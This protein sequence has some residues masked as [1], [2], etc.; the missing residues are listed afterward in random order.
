MKELTDSTVFNHSDKLQMH[1]LW[2]TYTIGYKGKIIHNQQYTEKIGPLIA[3]DTMSPHAV[4][5]VLCRA[6]QSVLLS[7]IML[8]MKCDTLTLPTDSSFVRTAS[9]LIAGFAAMMRSDIHRSLYA[10]YLKDQAYLEEGYDL[11]HTRNRDY[12]MDSLEGAKFRAY[13]QRAEEYIKRLVADSKYRQVKKVT[14]TDLP[15]CSI[16]S[17]LSALSK[18]KNV[19]D[20]ERHA[21]QAKSSISINHLSYLDEYISG[22]HSSNRSI[23]SPDIGH[24]THSASRPRSKKLSK[25]ASHEVLGKSSLG[26]TISSNRVQ[27]LPSRDQ[28]RDPKHC[29]SDSAPVPVASASGTGLHIGK[30]LPSVNIGKSVDQRTK[31]ALL[32]DKS[33]KKRGY[34]F[35]N[36]M[37]SAVD[38]VQLWLPSKLRVAFGQLSV[39]GH[40]RHRASSDLWDSNEE[41]GTEVDSNEEYGS[42]GDSNEE[43]SSEEDSNEEHGSEG[44][45]NEEYSSEGDSGDLS[46]SE[47]FNQN[48]QTSVFSGDSEFTRTPADIE[49]SHHSDGSN[50]AELMSSNGTTSSVPTPAHSLGG[51]FRD[52]AAV[53]VSEGER[54]AYLMKGRAVSEATAPKCRSDA[55]LAADCSTDTREETT[56]LLLELANGS[57]AS[58]LDDEDISSPTMVRYIQPVTASSPDCSSG[59]PILYSEWIP[60]ES[61]AVTSMPDVNSNIETQRFYACSDADGGTSTIS[62]VSSSFWFG[63]PM[64]HPQDESG[65]SVPEE[66][67]T[68]LADY[69]GL[70]ATGLSMADY[71]GFGTTGSSMADY[72]GLRATGSSMADY[73][74]LRATGSSMADYS[75]L[76]ATGSSMADYSGLG[77]TGSSMA[78][79]SGLRATGS[80]MADYS[81]LRAT[82]SSM[83]DYSGLRATGSSMADYSGLGATGSSM[84]D[85]SG[86][87]ATGSSMADYSGLRATGSSMADYS[88]LRATGFTAQYRLGATATQTAVLD[89]SHSRGMEA[90]DD[91]APLSL[92]PIIVH[93][94]GALPPWATRTARIDL[95]QAANR[96]F[97][98][99]RTRRGSYDDDWPHNSGIDPANM[100]LAGFYRIGKLGVC[101]RWHAWLGCVTTYMWT[102]TSFPHPQFLF[103]PLPDS[104]SLCLV[105]VV[106]VV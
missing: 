2:E 48:N 44:D 105:V 83:A 46:G 68:A 57:H 17:S 69:S 31:S 49:S 91:S 9:F 24:K 70:R 85:Y 74:G 97:V 77:A 35:R 12:D 78:D 30:E 1:I 72:S 94:A 62:P 95:S 18:T 16:G 106:V 92:P 4:Y 98:Q 10:G 33:Q 11:E 45:S 82:G 59:H 39:T 20:R 3:M 14:Q 56:P 53:G 67:W 50:V 22:V 58:S 61:P 93:A 38:F 96:E 34:G 7:Q 66:Q 81:G 89:A 104:V 23:S 41:Y 43:H 79:Y 88:G 5:I 102:M 19:D 6:H 21:M 75:G 51:H 42:E 100:A 26:S 87:R 28:L 71:S 80:S 60:F 84:A 99:L 32:E 37:Q 73:S 15:K 27:L 101:R 103:L 25:V 13:V 65:L 76:G 36:I 86:L 40:S 29:E 54:E 52:V 63:Q 64:A 47:V 8:M 90:H 55:D